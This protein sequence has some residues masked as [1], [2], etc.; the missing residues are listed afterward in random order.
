V[1]VL[2]DDPETGLP[3]T[4]RDGRFGTFIQLGEAAEGE[5]PKRSSIP[6]GVEASSLDLER[7]LAYLSLPREITKHP[8]TGQ[9]ILAGIGRYG[10]YVQHGKTYASLGRDDDVLEIGANRAV[11]LVMTK[12][13]GGGRGGRTQDPGKPLGDDP[14]TGKPVVLKAGRYG[15]YV[16]DG[17]TN[18]TLPR[19]QS[20][21]S[22]T[23]D[24]AL[25]LLVARRAAGPSKPKR[26]AARTRTASAAKA[27]AKRAAAKPAAAKAKKAAPAKRAKAKS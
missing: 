17:E 16:T 24:E 12:E 19:E 20:A 4:I 9:P 22:L 27:P 11:D 13:A 25:Q 6:K 23:L 21:E 2:G 15:N 7:A 5:K 10:P 14:E 8:E 26:G 18:A 3:V 1:R